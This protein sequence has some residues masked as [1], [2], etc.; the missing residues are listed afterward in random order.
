MRVMVD[1][2]EFAVEVDAARELEE[3]LSGLGLVAR[4]IRVDGVELVNASLE[5]VF[6]RA[7]VGMVVEVETAAARE[8]VEDA[9]A[10]ARAYVPRLRL[11]LEELGERVAYGDPGDARKLV[12]QALEGL[13]WIGLAFRAYFA[14]R[15]ESAQQEVFT[16]SLSRLLPSLRQ[17]EEAL[18]EEDLETVAA[19]LT[20][21]VAPF[22]E[23]LEGL[24]EELETEEEGEE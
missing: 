3:H 20:E 14:R 10:E 13:E 15:P 1:G 23:G 19:L 5:E 21:E 24:M 6:S 4:N 7:V 8:L 17:M 9:M 11:G 18:R 12:A 22:L 2:R 16:R